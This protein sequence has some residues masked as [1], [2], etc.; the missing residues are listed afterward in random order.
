MN[1]NVLQLQRENKMLKEILEYLTQLE[2]NQIYLTEVY[3]RHAS[4]TIPVMEDLPKNLK[5][6][7]YL[8]NIKTK[9]IEIKRRN[10]NYP[11]AYDEDTHNL[12]IIKW[13]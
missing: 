13:K 9:R 2:I 8:P 6:K 1:N 5:N 4:I 3:E 7:D 11:V 12:Y 10:S